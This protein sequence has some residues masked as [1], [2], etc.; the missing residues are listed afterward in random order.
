MFGVLTADLGPTSILGVQNTMRPALNKV[1]TCNTG[2][3]DYGC[4]RKVSE[5]IINADQKADLTVPSGQ[6]T[7]LQFKVGPAASPSA[8]Y[9]M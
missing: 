7:F 6:W 4:N 8:K 1:C 2:Y 3:G 9:H 5:I